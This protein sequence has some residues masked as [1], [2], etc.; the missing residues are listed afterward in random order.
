MPR[1]GKRGAD[2]VDITVI[3]EDASLRQLLCGELLRVGYS[4]SADK[5]SCKLLIVDGD[6]SVCE[7]RARSVRRKKV[8]TVTRREEKFPSGAVLRRPVLVSELRDAV[9]GLLDR[10][11]GA[12][13]AVQAAPKPSRLTLDE[14]KRA[15]YLG[16]RE[17]GLS[18]NEF[19]VLSLLFERRG[20]AV[21]RE[22]LLCAIGGAGNEADVYVC[23][24]RRKLESGG[25]RVIFTVRGRGYKLI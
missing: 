11:A 17:V 23:H 6:S 24:L 4:V 5:K 15:A 1:R 12:S 21:S 2:V 9:A 14:K 16:G 10:P 18:E 8:L 3:A 19:A 13:A 22:E 7:E 25:R 20:E